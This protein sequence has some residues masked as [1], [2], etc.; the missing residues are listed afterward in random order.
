[1]V[2]VVVVVEVVA[3]TEAA[4]I[5]VVLTVVPVTALVVVAVPRVAVLLQTM[6]LIVHHGSDH[7]IALNYPSTLLSTEICFG[8]FFVGFF[9]TNMDL[10]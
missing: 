5:T 1:M 2:V 4:V 8:V 6:H 3:A 7:S 10:S 9:I